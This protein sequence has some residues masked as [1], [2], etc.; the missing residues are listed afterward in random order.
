MK[1]DQDQYLPRKVREDKKL[2]HD[3]KK[4]IAAVFRLSS[5]QVAADTGMSKDETLKG[6]IGL[7]DAG[8]MKIFMDAKKDTIALRPCL[9]DGTV[10][11]EMKGF[12]FKI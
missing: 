9:E 5:E 4:L 1:T 8:H 7:C 12:A 10:V 6:L 3:A 2:D 11:E